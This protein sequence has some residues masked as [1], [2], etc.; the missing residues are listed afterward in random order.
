MNKLLQVL[1]R[2]HYEPM[3]R[4]NLWVGN[5]RKRGGM[6]SFSVANYGFVLK[7]K[8]KKLKKWEKNFNQRKWVKWCCIQPDFGY[9]NKLI[10]KKILQFKGVV[11]NL[12][13]LVD[14]KMFFPSSWRNCIPFPLMVISFLY[15]DF[16]LYINI[17]LDKKSFD[18]VIFIIDCV[19]V[20]F[21]YNYD[22]CVQEKSSKI[23]VTL[24]PSLYL[25]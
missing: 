2:L 21:L 19:W 7:K 6:S 22:S 18:I 9:E 3:K 16:G 10:R 1:H 25:L 17:D 11:I 4:V 5:K 8:I 20:L 14:F 12:S 13:F 15:F 23:Y 24:F